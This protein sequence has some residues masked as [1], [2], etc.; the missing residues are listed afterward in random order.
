MAGEMEALYLAKFL[1]DAGTAT[2]Q[3]QQDLQEV[4]ARRRNAYKQATMNNN[5][6]YVA[7]LHI[8]EEDALDLKKTGL[9]NEELRQLM[10]RTSAKQA[11]QDASIGGGFGR[12]G[13]SV[14]ATQLNIER[15]GYKALARK[16]LNREIRE[17][18]FRQRK[19]NIANEALSKN[20][21]LMSG[22][23]VAP[24]GTG[25]ALQIAGSGIQSAIG[26]KQGTT[27]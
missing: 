16:D 3:H 25:L 12:S 23:P 10:R 26:S 24:S 20:N 22:I 9:D 1:F 4:E 2:Y 11:A 19:Q 8:N 14:Q 13:Q 18:S 15:H 7:Q 5:L 6:A 21:A 17:M 27:E